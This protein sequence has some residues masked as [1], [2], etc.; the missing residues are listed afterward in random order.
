MLRSR[1]LVWLLLALA[2]AAATGLRQ[3]PPP[4]IDAHALLVSADPPVNSQIREPPRE[5]TLSF[6][7]P[8]E[9]KFSS[10]RVVD[11]TGLRVDEG[12]SFDD[13]NPALMRVALKPV[14][15]GYLVVSWQNV[16]TVDGHRISGSYP[17][18]ILNA[19]GSLPAGQS[20]GLAASTSGASARPERV[21][22]KALLLIAG[23]LLAGAFAFLFW[24]TPGLPGDEP[25]GTR[26]GIESKALALASASLLV[27][28]LVGLLELQLQANEIDAGLGS[29]LDTR[30]GERWLL[31]HI[32]LA[33]PALAL[34][35]GR[36]ISGWRREAA[37]AGIAGMMGY[38]LL[39]ASV[40]HGSAG[41][42]AF[43]GGLS[44]FVHLLA[45]S[46]WLG[47]LPLLALL[48]FMSPAPAGSKPRLTLLATAL[49]R[50]SVVAV[51]SLALLLFTG[52][53]NALIQVGQLSDLLNTAYGRALLIKLALLLPL[54][55]LGG[56]NAYIYRPRFI[57]TLD[58]KPRDEPQFLTELQASLSRT[59]RLE[60]AVAVC[61]LAVVALLVQLTPARGGGDM[62]SAAG[63]LTT[64]DTAEDVAVTLVIDP[65]QP[66][67]NTFEV[68]LAG[69]ADT[70]ERVRL[71]FNPKGRPDEA[72]RLI[73][74]LS[75]YP[76]FYVG[77]GAFLSSGGDW[78]ITVD[79][80]RRTGNDLRLTFPVKVSGA[81]SQ[82]AK[83]E[84]DFAAPLTFSLATMALLAL[85]AALA[86]A[87][88]LASR[89]QPG[90]PGGWMGELAERAVEVVGP[91]LRSSW[92]LAVL[93][94]MG[95]GVGLIVGSH[96]HTRLTPEQAGQGNQVPSSEQSIARGLDLFMRNCSQC[97][98]ESGRGD[99]PLAS[100]LPLPP[101]NLYLHIPF[102]PDQFFFS[103]I[104]NGLSGIMP[105][106]REQL[107]EEDRWHVLNFLRSQF[108]QEPATQ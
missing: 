87:L 88:V 53:V 21:A 64:T 13:T 57:Y 3:G 98:G 4:R 9:R 35:G 108:G 91:Q 93:L 2:L 22:T 1:R 82:T 94:V 24:V 71:D 46:V 79:L 61:V 49:Q 25:G 67:N 8:L 6:S 78:Q 31:R 59:I 80:R 69:A 68:Y 74:D 7:E 83:P 102:H 99:G 101:A 36:V 38:F 84:G 42:G 40:S 81:A 76:T 41:V 12:V 52:V 63:K 54:L 14:G 96:V 19:D 32:L 105:A 89:P 60:I 16:S 26:A 45:A 55:A 15:A 72:S 17:L 48:F 95:I 51:L 86:L 65:N 50:F 56:F 75:N 58:A 10:V 34:I 70:V 106:F 18:T 103:V 77:Q 30:W 28:F 37:A 97:H 27:L 43:W 23:S 85:A 66:G 44:D 73:L 90:L 5:L 11:A 92:S 29:A 104:T 107:S 47:M 20:P 33:F 62:I 39:V 100:S